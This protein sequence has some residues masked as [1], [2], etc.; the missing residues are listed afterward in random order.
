MPPVLIDFHQMVD[1][2]LATPEMG[3]INV[4]VLHSL[5]HCLVHK[6]SISSHGVEFHGP[7]SER[8]EQ[9]IPAIPTLSPIYLKEYTVP[10]PK[11]PQNRK[12]IT[13]PLQVHPI[14]TIITINSISV[15]N[16]KPP[17]GLPL[18]PLHIMS[19]TDVEIL[20]NRVTSIHDALA[21]VLPTDEVLLE[22]ND[23]NCPTGPL[24]RMNRIINTAKRVD[25]VEIGLRK[26]AE[27]V[28]FLAS[29]CGKPCDCEDEEDSTG[30]GSASSGSESGSSDADMFPTVTNYETVI[31]PVIGSVKAST[32]EGNKT[33][34]AKNGSKVSQ[35]NR[36]SSQRQS[37]ID[38]SNNSN[39]KH[40]SVNKES[41]EDPRKSS[42]SAG[43]PLEAEDPTKSSTSAG[44]ALQEIET[45]DKEG[46]VKSESKKEGK[47]KTDQ[48][49][50]NKETKIEKSKEK[51]EKNVTTT[52]DQPEDSNKNTQNNPYDSPDD[53]DNDEWFIPG[54]PSEVT[55]GG[56]VPFKPPNKGKG[57]KKQK[58]SGNS[59]TG[60][61]EYKQE[62]L[63]LI[64][65]L[66]KQIAEVQTQ[67]VENYSQL[68]SRL[69][70]FEITFAAL[71]RATEEE[72]RCSLS[73]YHNQ[74]IQTMIEVQD[75]LD[76]KV[77]KH[78]IPALKQFI[79]DTLNEF[80]GTLEY[81]RREFGMIPDAA[82]T[83]IRKLR[84]VDC[85]SCQKPVF[86]ADREQPPY[87][88]L[89]QGATPFKVVPTPEKRY[90]G[91]GHTTTTALER[92][93]VE[94][95][96]ITQHG[97]VG[98]NKDV[99]LEMGTDGALYRVKEGCPCRRP[100]P[101]S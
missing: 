27:M 29:S 98:N 83:T 2:A 95:N 86:Q 71:I 52:D 11:E 3:M 72:F 42:T 90:C 45:N 61:E 25:A 34:S 55:D 7:N 51:R 46:I 69:N 78:T 101:R 99:D 32:E 73:K 8:I 56:S 10:N 54:L 39:L 22:T 91:G 44:K 5:L 53:F 67:G 89:T 18:A 14:N 41:D 47:G 58:P 100:K 77:E 79:V 20:K 75:M 80:R 57:S 37:N 24:A 1:L 66:A 63:E 13:M 94:G 31:T 76:A 43:K 6:L 16:S 59:S 36:E 49:N 40:E 26:M 62:I 28:T 9:L 19:T 97:A 21:S 92:T 88:P 12:D 60:H 17:A 30:E 85:L 48:M 35:N 93:L 33:K 65:T 74:F 82:A 96:F 68:E 4:P 23:E 84:N 15:P 50:K 70:N 38:T 81:F 87:V 64:E